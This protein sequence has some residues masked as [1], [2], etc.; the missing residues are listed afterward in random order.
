M[1]AE[2]NTAGDH[3]APCNVSQPPNTLVTAVQFLLPPRASCLGLAI[4]V[5]G[6]IAAGQ[7]GWSSGAATA[8]HRRD[9]GR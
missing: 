8:P 3:D 5:Y 9:T 6:F 1:T 7:Y 4:L 2:R